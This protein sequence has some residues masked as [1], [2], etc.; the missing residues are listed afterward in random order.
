MP[1]H[2]KYSNSPIRDLDELY[3][4]LEGLETYGFMHEE[5]Y[6]QIDWVMQ[7]L[8]LSEARKFLK[9]PR[10]AMIFEPLATR[11][12]GTGLAVQAPGGD[13]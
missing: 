4:L 9:S 3:V 5:T 11:I 8:Y 10:R 2:P 7:Q 12:N 13:T 6:Q 1:Q